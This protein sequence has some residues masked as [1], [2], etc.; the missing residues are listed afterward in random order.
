MVVSSQALIN[1]LNERNL[2][3]GASAKQGRMSAWMAIDAQ[4]KRH[5]V[6]FNRK[7]GKWELGKETQP[8]QGKA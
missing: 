7:A 3:L 2:F 1:A 5:F 4:G 6:N 8:R